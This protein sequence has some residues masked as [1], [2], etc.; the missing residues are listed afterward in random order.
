MVNTDLVF[1]LGSEDALLLVLA[2]LLDD[3]SLLFLADLPARL[4]AP[5]LL[6]QVTLTLLSRSPPGQLL[7]PRRAHDRQTVAST[8]LTMTSY[9]K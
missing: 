3:D 5:L 6:G 1:L 2:D 4:L 7:C 8:E 9:I